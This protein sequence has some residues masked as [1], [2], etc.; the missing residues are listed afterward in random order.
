MKTLILGGARSG[1][2]KRAEALAEASGKAVVYVATA[3]C[4][5]DDKEW[6]Q[7]IQQHQ[8]QRPAAWVVVEEQIGLVSLLQGGKYEE[9]ILLIDCLTLWL[10]NLM[11][12]EMDV[13]QEVSVF[14]RALSGYTGDVVMVS[15]EV[16]L[17]LVPETALGRE[18]RDEQGRLNQHVAVVADCVE[19]IAA[20]LPIKLKGDVNHR[21]T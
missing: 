13:A 14:C 17:G 8:R 20:G 21:A 3:S 10:S 16:G 12:A 18:F 6:Q 9:Y 5:P 19:F 1:K 2:S 11:F 4:F 15:N 7:R